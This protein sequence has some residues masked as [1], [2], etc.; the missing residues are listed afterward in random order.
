MY[1]LGQL[2]GLLSQHPLRYFGLPDDVLRLDGDGVRDHN[3]TAN[4][5]PLLVR[6]P[7]TCRES[8]A[9]KLTRQSTFDYAPFCVT[10]LWSTTASPGNDF[11]LIACE[12]IKYTGFPRIKAEGP[13]TVDSSTTTSSSR[14]T[15]ETT[16][17]TSST[18]SNGGDSTNTGNGGNGGQTQS[19]TPSG[20]SGQSAPVGAIVGGV[21]GGL[22]VLALAAVALVF[23][24]RSR[25]PKEGTPVNTMAA[26]SPYGSPPPQPMMQNQ[27]TPPPGFP[28]SQSA[29]SAAGYTA[30]NTTPSPGPGSLYPGAAGAPYQPGSPD[31]SKH[32]SNVS[33]EPAYGAYGTSPQ[34]QP[35]QQYNGY[36]QP[37]VAEMGTSNAAGSNA[38]RAELG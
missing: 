18:R 26:V 11:T 21:V 15:S 9:R 24:L 7:V 27:Q 38:N 32:Y 23:F 25:K 12:S 10:Y 5:S 30:Y 20:D 37:Y 13:A 4:R 34:P 33:S 19:S 29:Y 35:P 22:A 36:Q 2:P 17:T 14:T 28:P 8:N 16:T 1:Q 31:P 6:D 3:P